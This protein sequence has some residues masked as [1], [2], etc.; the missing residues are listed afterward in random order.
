MGICGKQLLFFFR[1]TFSALNLKIIFR[2]FDVVKFFPGEIGIWCAEF[3]ANDGFNRKRDLTHDDVKRCPWLRK[4][5]K[6]E[7][8]SAV[9]MTL[10]LNIAEPIHDQENMQKNRMQGI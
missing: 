5:P 4:L 8:I 7:N 3:F 10:S 1:C 2:I 9:F 6:Q